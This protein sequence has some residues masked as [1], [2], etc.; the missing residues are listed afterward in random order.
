MLLSILVA[1]LPLAGCLY[2]KPPRRPLPVPSSLTEPPR[3][4]GLAAAD[5]GDSAAVPVAPP[6]GPAAKPPPAGATTGQ[7][8]GGTAGFRPDPSAAL[9][10]PLTPSAIPGDTEAL[11]QAL[12][13][14]APVTYRIVGVGD[15]HGQDRTALLDAIMAQNGWPA[16]GQLV[17]AVFT[18]DGHDLRFGTGNVFRQKGVT[19]AE[20]LE[21][22]RTHYQP[23]ARRGD[24]A[25]GLAR[26]IR[27]V[28][29]RVR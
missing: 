25:A 4:S 28:N 19:V 9:P 8:G 3:S 2:R 6:S 14:D 17:L 15:S 5:S 22:V 10:E 12:A 1:A 29:R 23:E 26:L 20:I 27:A 13:E 18:E 16:A 7:P 11:R 24:P 21:L